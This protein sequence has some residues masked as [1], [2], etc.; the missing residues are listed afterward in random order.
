MAQTLLQR[1]RGYFPQPGGLRLRF[2]ER[3]ECPEVSVGEALPCLTVGRGLVGERVS[4]DPAAPAKGSSKCLALLSSGIEPISVGAF[5]QA[6][7]E[8]FFSPSKE[9]ETR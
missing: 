6:H 1:H 7:T 5:G 2:P 8:V 4:I 3:E 9:A